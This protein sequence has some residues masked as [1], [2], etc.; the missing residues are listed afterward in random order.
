MAKRR[1]LLRGALV[2]AVCA[3]A[4]VPTAM[5]AQFHRA[6]QDREITYWLLEPGTHQFKISHDLTIDRPGQKYAHSF[7]RKGSAVDPNAKMYDADTGKE[8]K[9][10]TVTGKEVNALGYYP[11]PS[12]PETVVVQGDLDRTPGEGQSVR[13]RV[14]ETYTDP[15]GYTMDGQELVWK[16]TLGRPLNVVTLPTGWMLSS[17][18]TPA[19]ISMDEQGRVALRF[20]NPRNDELNITLRARKRSAAH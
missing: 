14:V 2:A 16:R 4:I 12:E 20:T 8:L 19:I 13:V 5:R 18:D 1:Y 11:Q 6:E 10:Y 7:V 15:V 3:A 9:T 17:L